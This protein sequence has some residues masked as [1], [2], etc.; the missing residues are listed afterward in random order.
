MLRPPVRDTQY[1]VER[2]D[3]RR[4]DR[5][6]IGVVRL[7]GDPSRER[8]PRAD[9]RPTR[10]ICCCRTNMLGSNVLVAPRRTHTDLVHHAQS[11]PHCSRRENPV[12]TNQCESV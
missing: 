11:S 2:D 4:G 9:R 6:A 3:E 1:S 12:I 10:R 5:C 8:V 7:R